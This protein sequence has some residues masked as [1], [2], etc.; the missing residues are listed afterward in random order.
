MSHKIEFELKQ[1]ADQV[2]KRARLAAEKNG[3][4]MVGDASAGKFVGH[5]LEGHYTIAGRTVAITIHRKPMLV[6]WAMIE[7]RLHEFFSS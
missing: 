2:I 5:G 7:S 1:E 6:P 3:V 4:H